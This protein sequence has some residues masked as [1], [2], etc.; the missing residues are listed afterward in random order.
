MRRD[1]ENAVGERCTGV[2]GRPCEF[3]RLDA[4]RLR[5]K[6]DLTDASLRSSPPQLHQKASPV[7]LSRLLSPSS[8][9]PKPQLRGPP[10]EIVEA[11]G[12]ALEAVRYL[13]D[14]LNTTVRLGY[15]FLLLEIG[16]CPEV[17]A[18]VPERLDSTFL[19][20]L[21]YGRWEEC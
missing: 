15:S 11:A 20:L 10:H 12:V 5:W 8:A 19:V 7:R 4:E 2:D 16:D 18:P 21:G 1:V 14:R 6:P 3:D 9:H 17:P 13:D